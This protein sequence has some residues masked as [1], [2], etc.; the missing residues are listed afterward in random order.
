MKRQVIFI[1]S[2]LSI[3]IAVWSCQ[4]P[5]SDQPLPEQELSDEVI[6]FNLS[7]GGKTDPELLIGEW[8]CVRFAYTE[9]GNTISDVAAI[10]KGWLTIPV[11]ATPK[12]NDLTNQWRLDYHTNS[13]GFICLL[14]G[15]LIELVQNEN[16]FTLRSSPEEIDIVFALTNAYSYVIKGDEIIIYFTGAGNKNLLIL[17]KSSP[18]QEPLSDEHIS[19]NL[20]KNGKIDPELLIGQWDCVQF[21]Y[22]ADGNRISNVAAISLTPPTRCMLTIPFAP[23]PIPTPEEASYYWTLVVR[24]VMSYICSIEGNFIELF[25]YTAYGA[26]LPIPHLEYDLRNALKDA[27][28][29]VVIGNELIIYF[30]EIEDENILFRCTLIQN[31]NL[32]ILKKR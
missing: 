2:A 19:F 15:N 20:S 9:D 25:L 29:F 3:M 12:E 11:A 5:K 16:G 30:P 7:E 31:K 18:L 1:I 22:T 27:K 17:R 26:G 21:A 13:I 24:N 6:A 23:T 28:S 14:K 8:D 32:L 10:S 4:S